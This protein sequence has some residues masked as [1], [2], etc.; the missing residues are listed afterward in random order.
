MR[1]YVNTF[2]AAGCVESSEGS[3]S[4]SIESSCWTAFQQCKSS[5]G[6]GGISYQSWC[7]EDEQDNTLGLTECI[8]QQ[9]Y[10][11]TI[12]NQ[13]LCSGSSLTEAEC[14]K[15]C[16]SVY[17]DNTLQECIDDACRWRWVICTQ[18]NICD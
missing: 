10:R 5:G 11:E 1:S 7:I 17:E 2:L 3:G 12:C 9:V 14:L 16:M 4:S 18:E 13:T 15:V 8:A 6:W